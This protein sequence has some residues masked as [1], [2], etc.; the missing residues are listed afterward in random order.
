MLKIARSMSELPFE[1]LME[2][3]KET[4]I[5]SAERHWGSVS[6]AYGL[7]MAQRLFYEQL[8]CGFYSI[9]DAMYCLW[10]VDGECVSALRLEPWKD[11]WLLAALETAPAHRKRGY[12]QALVTAVQGYLMA[13]GAVRLYSHISQRNVA[14]IRVHQRCGFKKIADTARLLDGTV[15]SQMGTYL[16]DE[17]ASVVE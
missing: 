1:Q 16:Y 12:A 10:F 2:V 11:G 4:N 13:Q 3:Y 15:T 17:N 6:S 7:T 5:R 9:P 8:Q 14:S